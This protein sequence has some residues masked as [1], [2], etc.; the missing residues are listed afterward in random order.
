[1]PAEP[2]RPHHDDGT[3]TSPRRRPTAE[4]VAVFTVCAVLYLVV[5]W[6]FWRNLLIPSDAVSRVANAYYTVY[7]RD[8][9]MAAM[10][11]VW[12]PLPSFLLLPLLPLGVVLPALTV[13]GLATTLLSIVCMAGAVTV[14]GD[15]LRRLGVPTPARICLSAAFALHPMIILYG[16]N[17][18]SEAL[19]LLLLVVVARALLGWLTARTSGHL[20]VV[21]LGLALAYGTRYEALATGA[22]CGVL[23]AAATWW[24]H[25]HEPRRR[26]QLA[27]ADLALVT[28]PLALAVG[29]WALIGWIVSGEWFP[30]FT[31]EYGNSAQVKANLSG[32]EALVGDTVPDRIRYAAEQINGLEPM[33]AALLLGA[34]ALA[35]RRRDWRTASPLAVFG[36]V[37][38]FHVLILAE[39]SSYGWLRFQIVVVPLTVLTCGVLVAALWHHRAGRWRLTATVAVVLAA[40]AGIPAAVS[41]LGDPALARGETAWTTPDGRASESG[42]AALNKT[43]AADIDATALPEGAVITDSAYAFGII[44]AT[45]RPEQFVINSD[46]DFAGALA[47]PRGHGVQYL[48]VSVY[49][50]ADAIRMAYPDAI[51]SGAPPPG[52]RVWTDPAGAPQWFLVPLA[53]LD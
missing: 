42:R 52:T 20:V 21:G 32:I 48:L 36:S 1:M 6:W 26:W 27:Q 34:A 14:V 39:G 45:S 49:G 38:V 35:I 3:S 33:L 28:F 4:G 13:D 43:I 2:A 9:H 24:S 37:S 22:A 7:S 41:A 31:S 18:M 23:V 15:T 53:N 50:P 16:G 25:R 47:D 44:L 5:A 30:T 12:N 11:V 8:P 19:F 17:G 29:L 40:G 46:R 51:P 10:G